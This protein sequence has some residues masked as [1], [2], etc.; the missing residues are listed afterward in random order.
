MHCRYFSCRDG[1]QVQCE[2]GGS[3]V[4]LR[5]GAGDILC[6]S[7]RNARAGDITEGVL[8]G[9][10]M[11]QN[12]AKPDVLIPARVPFALLPPEMRPPLLQIC[13]A[14]M[15]LRIPG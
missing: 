8:F 9:I 11:A 13:Q 4:L 15:P 10:V 3:R 2:K 6:A 5:G 12:I 14:I 7:R 1:D